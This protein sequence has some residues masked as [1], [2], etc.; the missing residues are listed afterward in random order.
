MAEICKWGYLEGR[1][2]D[3][4]DRMNWAHGHY[5]IPNEDFLYVL[6][7][8]IYEPIRWIDKY[9]WRPT[10]EVEKRGYYF[11]WR[12]VGKRMGMRDIPPSYEEFG[13]WKAD[14]ER[15][16][17]VFADTN[18]RI[19][20]LTRDLFA[21]WF[22]RIFTPMVRYTIYAMLDDTMLESFGFPKPFPFARTLVDKSLRLRGRIVRWLPPRRKPHFFMDNRNRSYPRGYSIPKLGPPKLIENNAR[23]RNE[24]EVTFKKTAEAQ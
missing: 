2:K 24:S 3:A 4:L 22:L 19:G 7:T 5:K 15:K 20:S 16:H 18:N 21:S 13:Q 10:C 6:S 1:G 8:F 17:F 23:S 11:F 14:F 9:G 12:E